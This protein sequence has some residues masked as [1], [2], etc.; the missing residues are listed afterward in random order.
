MFLVLRMKDGSRV[1]NS[2]Q[3]PLKTGA[4]DLLSSENVKFS[5]VALAARELRLKW[6]FKP[7]YTGGANPSRERLL[8]ETR[9]NESGLI[10]MNIDTGALIP[11]APVARSLTPGDSFRAIQAR[12]VV[13]NGIVASWRQTGRL[14]E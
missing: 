8:V 3:I 13:E 1:S 2:P 11:T 7:H 5:E 10:T 12:R 4:S 6:T 9:Q 14:I